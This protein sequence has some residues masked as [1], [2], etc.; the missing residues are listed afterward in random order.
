MSSGAVPP[1]N[2]VAPNVSASVPMLVVTPVSIVAY[3]SLSIVAPLRFMSSMPPTVPA[4][5]PPTAV[6]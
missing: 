5:T 2:M 1:A 6:V 3:S 4:V